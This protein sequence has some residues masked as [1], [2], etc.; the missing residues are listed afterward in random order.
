[1]VSFFQSY[2]L[3]LQFD[4]VFYPICRLKNTEI[5]LSK[6]INYRITLYYFSSR[7]KYVVALLCVF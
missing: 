1:M 6:L 4:Q 3:N 2:F 7:S 5:E